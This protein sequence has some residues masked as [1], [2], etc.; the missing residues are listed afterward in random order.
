M[1]AKRQRVQPTKDNFSYK[2]ELHVHLDGAFRIS[3]LLE[4]ARAKNFDLKASTLEEFRREI[5]VYHAKSLYKVLQSF[6]IFMHIVAGDRD[7]I[8]RLAYEFCEDCSLNNIR[9]VEAR[10]SPHLLANNEEKPEYA[11]Q[12]GDLTPREVVQIV[13]DAVKR[14]SADFKVN[15][16]TILCCMRHRPDWSEEVVDLAYEYRNVGVVGIDIA[17]GSNQPEDT[18]HVLPQHKKAFD[19]ARQLGLHI[20]VHAGEAGSADRVKEALDDLH[21]ERI[22]HGYRVL[23]NPAIYKEVRDKHVHLETC[24]ISSICTGAVPEDIH[25]HPVVRFA[26]DGANFSLNSDDP[27]VFDSCLLDDYLAAIESGL[28]EEHVITS[29]FNAA[30]SCFSTDEEKQQIL[31][32]LVEVYGNKY[33]QQ[34]Q[35]P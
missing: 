35:E 17:G 27:L 14:G 8:A 32:D 15:V 25:Q 4:I 9:Y 34:A 18:E 20:T 16:K 1:E 12:H 28:T 31:K 30:Q 33:L 2:I 21:A 7:A 11:L 6:D 3:S 29:I 13:N 23:E 22:G 10:Y 26:H 5:C 24:P 19:R